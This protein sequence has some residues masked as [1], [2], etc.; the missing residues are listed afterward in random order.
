MRFSFFFVI[1]FFESILACFW[2]V[3]LHASHRRPQWHC[4]LF[5][6]EISSPGTVSQEGPGF[7]TVT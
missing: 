7:R 1:G 6:R 4:L 5:S 3:L 2:N